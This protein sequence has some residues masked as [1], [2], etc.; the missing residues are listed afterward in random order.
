MNSVILIPSMCLRNLRPPQG[1]DRT[2]Y[3]KLAFNLL[4]Q[5]APIN[6]RMLEGD[7]EYAG[8]TPGQFRQKFSSGAET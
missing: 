5:V 7:Q 2:D 3:G 6:E 1:S 4:V 8:S